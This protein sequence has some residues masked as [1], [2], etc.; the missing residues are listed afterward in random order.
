MKKRILSMVLALT[1]LCSMLPMAAADGF[2]RTKSWSDTMFTDVAKADWFYENVKEAYELGLMVG[3]GDG[4]FNPT[5]N[6]TMAQTIAVAA[7][8]HAI[9]TKGEESFEQGSP[10]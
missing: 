5:G 3:Y 7:R 6:I 4:T 8:V 10:W 2:T 1:I 9:A